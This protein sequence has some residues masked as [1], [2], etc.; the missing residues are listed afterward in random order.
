[1]LGRARRTDAGILQACTGQVYGDPTV[2]LQPDSYQ[3]SVNPIGLRSR[4]DESKRCAETPFF[5]DRRQRTLSIKVARIF[6]SC[7]LRTHP[8]DGRVV[9][10][11]IVQGASE[12]RCHHLRGRLDEGLRV[13]NPLF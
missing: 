3:G 2:G 9:S 12:S 11:F 4:Y 13:H 5:D 10:N 1:M 7:G 6:D 8:N